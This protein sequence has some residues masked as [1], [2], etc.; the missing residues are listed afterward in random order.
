MTDYEFDLTS[1]FL[2]TGKGKIHYHEV[3]EGPTLLLLHGSGPGVTARANYQSN[4]PVFAT[5][6]RC[7]LPDF[8]GYGK[9]E[10]RDGGPVDVCVDATVELMDSLGV[11]SSHIIGNSLGGIVGSHIAAR[12][13]ER[14]GRFVTI[15][16]I[17]LNVFSGFPGEGLNLMT[18]FV[19]EPTRGRIEQWL[20]SMVYDQS[21]VTD[22][23]IDMRL[24]QALEPVTFASTKQLYGRAAIHAQA[25]FREGVGSI[26]T[27][28]HLAKIQAPTLVTWGRDDR[29]SPLDIGLIPMRIIPDAELHVF[30]KC[31][32]WVMIEK[33]HEFE[34]LVMSFLTRAH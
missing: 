34:T 8:P 3:G 26:A 18:E 6:F 23:L 27:I 24:E 25:R 29:V 20:R 12:L 9:S 33:K 14:V 16:G 2:D 28:E 5:E 32:H 1:K 11:A 7:V 21:I 10:P 30:P 17:G 4:L 15:G 13:P 19:Q 22:E 31:G